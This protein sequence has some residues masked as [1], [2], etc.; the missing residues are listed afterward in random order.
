MPVLRELAHGLARQPLDMP[1]VDPG[2][3][4]RL[5]TGSIAITRVPPYDWPWTWSATNGSATAPVAADQ[6]AGT[7]SCF[8]WSNNGGASA[9]AAAVGI[10]FRPPF[11]GVGIVSIDATPAFNYLWWTYN[12]FDSSHSDAWIG[13]YVGAYDSGGTFIS[14]PIDQQLYLWNESHD[15]LSSPDGSGSNSGYPL[16]GATFVNGNQFYEIWVWCGGS[17]SGDGDHTFW[18]SWAGSSLNVSVPSIHLEYFGGG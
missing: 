7:L 18:G 3:S 13:L 17:A 11:P 4:D 9:G 14:A 10:Y 2:V 1:S 8:E 15:F 5:T 6:S 12:A 16:N